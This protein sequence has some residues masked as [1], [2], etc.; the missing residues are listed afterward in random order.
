MKQRRLSFNELS[1]SFSPLVL[2]DLNEL[3]GGLYVTNPYDSNTVFTVDENN[4]N[5]TVTRGPAGMVWNST[6]QMFEMPNGNFSEPEPL[7]KTVNGVLYLSF[8]NGDSWTAYLNTVTIIGSGT[9]HGQFTDAV[10]QQMMLDNL[11][12]WAHI[13]Y[14]NGSGGGSG[15]TGGGGTGG[16]TGSGGDGNTGGGTTPLPSTTSI[17]IF[18]TFVGTQVMTH[19]QAYNMISDIQTHNGILTNILGYCPSWG[20]QVMGQAITFQN[21]SWSNLEGDLIN[22]GYNG[23]VTF[24]LT[25]G[26]QYGNS[27]AE[28]LD[29][30]GNVI[31]TA[32]GIM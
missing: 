28:L 18:G 27:I 12:N 10:A 25:V 8:D 16:G 3:K 5:V 30:N 29:A 17:D 32:Y 26:S 20:A 11:Y 7:E 14:G 19:L 24:R 21:M 1:N 2:S 31:S 22:S 15:G 9:N 23:N 6:M 4:G 13:Q